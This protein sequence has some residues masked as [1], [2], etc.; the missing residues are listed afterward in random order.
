MNS[1]PILAST[2]PKM[3]LRYLCTFFGGG[4]PDKSNEDYW[5]GNI[6]WVSPKD[7]KASEIYDT[8]DHISEQ[9]LLESATRLVNPG[10]VLVVMRSGILRHTIPVAINHVP[11]A[12]NQ[13]MKAIC[14]GSKL[15][16]R[17]LARYIEGQQARLLTLWGKEGATVESLE[18]DLIADTMIPLPPLETQRAIADFLDTET[19]RIDAL[20]EAK[21]NLLTIL[22]EKRRALITQ[23]VTRG[24]D[25]SV[26]M[27]DSAIPW[28]GE[29]PAHWEV[30]RLKFLLNGIEQGW[31]P[32]CDNYPA[33]LDE[34]GVLKSGCCNGG[35]FREDDNKSL[36]TNVEPRTQLEVQAGDVL[37]AR[38]SGSIELLGAA[39]RVPS[40]VRP[41]LL[42]SDLLYRLRV[43]KRLLNPDFL[44]YVLASQMG[45]TQ[46][47]MA[48]SSTGGLANKLPQ[49]AVA[50]FIVVTPPL[51]DQ[52]EVVR[53][54]NAELVM[55]VQMYV[56]TQR[57]IDLLRERR[58]SVIAAAVTGQMEALNAR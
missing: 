30:M 15:D 24:L 35:I 41:R 53:H 58:E 29:I 32:Q 27:R 42:F 45:R 23:A 50:E 8:E 21:E 39:A 12:L 26:P 18:S 51:A 16:A 37:M 3:R 57:T 49:S 13:D 9:A 36:P 22:A 11:V 1:T 43:H 48:I 4:T 7:M 56:A 44:V 47:Q 5:R 33:E 31:S 28:L 55:I 34:W 38:A 14:V 46:V 17:Y 40:N 52:E 54:V 19:A 6:P 2:W 10:A 20:I 25:P